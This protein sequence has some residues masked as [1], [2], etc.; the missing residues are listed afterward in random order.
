MFGEQRLITHIYINLFQ[1]KILHDF[2]WQFVDFK[3]ENFRHILL[4]SSE[5]EK[6]ILYKIIQ[7]YRVM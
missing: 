3:M 4:P 1:K 6:N 7:Y 5:K 2:S